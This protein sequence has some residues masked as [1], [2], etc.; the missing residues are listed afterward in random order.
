M[1]RKWRIWLS[2]RAAAERKQQNWELYFKNQ[3]K[4]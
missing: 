1:I 3:I 2:K 4:I